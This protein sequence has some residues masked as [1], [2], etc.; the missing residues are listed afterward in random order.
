MKVR[1][2]ISFIDDHNVDQEAD[3]FFAPG[4]SL[5]N[6]EP[7]TDLLLRANSDDEQEFVLL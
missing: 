4:S 1:E 5:D 3:V 2:L 6:Q 7:T